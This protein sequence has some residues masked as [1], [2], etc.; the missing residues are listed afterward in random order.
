MVF[1]TTAFDRSAISPLQKYIFFE[2]SNGSEKYFEN[3]LKAAVH[4]Y[5]VTLIK[6]KNRCCH[7]FFIAFLA[8]YALQ[9]GKYTT[10][11]STF[12]MKNLL[13]SSIFSLTV[14]GAFAQDLQA[15]F[16]YKVF[17]IPNEGPMVETYLNVFGNSLNYVSVEGGEVATV[18][19]L[20]IIKKG[21]EIIDYSK[22]S[23]SSP[24]IT[25]SVYTDFIDVQ[26]FAVPAGEYELE[27]ELYDA[28]FPD[29]VERILEPIDLRMPESP[30]FISDV[31]WIIAYKPT[32]E[33][34]VYSKSGYDLLPHVSNYFPQ[35]M[36][37][38]MFYSEIYG[39]DTKL[40][41]DE[42]FLLS[43]FVEKKESKKVIESMTSRSKK[44]TNSVVPVLSQ[45]DITNLPTGN[46]NLV[47]EVRDRNN[48]LQASQAIFFQRVG[49][50]VETPSIDYAEH[51]IGQTFVSELNSID[52]LGEFIQ[53]LRPIA[54]ANESPLIDRFAKHK[55][56]ELMKRFFYGFWHERNPDQPDVAWQ[57]YKTKVADVNRTYS[58]AIKKGYETDMGRIYLQYGPPNTI[59][60]RPS[61]PS[62][63][64][65]QIWQYFRADRWTNV[66]FVFYDRTL[67]KQD[68]ELLH[69]D[70]IPGEIKNQ[71]WDI[72]VHQRD[73]PM[74]NVDDNQ[75]RQHFGGRTQDYWDTPR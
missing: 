35:Y 15:F 29:N 37:K 14:L 53:C 66:R 32:T 40:G 58:T 9:I 19:L 23:I 22:K 12:D 21:T 74:R 38:M 59:T 41:A 4:I 36:S 2:T 3:R 56:L 52:T 47:I 73:T 18:E 30:L 17:H 51:L 68:Y 50:E 69:C 45:F 65:Y 26:R 72:L 44:T 20:L 10:P 1:K 6:L 11:K 75:G 13:F 46:Y 16:D 62:A 31:Q 39:T 27:L 28:S 63:Y 71:R 61:E 25:D 54:G 7:H 33:A 24:L 55:D 49:N 60:D 70:N 34:T 64:P 5:F 42:S 57:E 67:L 43:A 48:E 8:D